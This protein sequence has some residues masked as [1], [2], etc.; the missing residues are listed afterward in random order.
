MFKVYLAVLG[1]MIFSS[2]MIRQNK[3]VTEDKNVYSCMV[4]L[5]NYYGEGAYVAVSLVDQFD[6]YVKTLRVLGDQKEW[7]PDMP[8]WWGFSKGSNEKLDGLTGATIA[9]GERSIFSIEIEEE[10]L[11]DGHKIRFETAVENQK[12]FEED[13]KV[14]LDSS[15]VTGKFEGTGY[16]RYVRI[17]PK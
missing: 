5:T 6:N 1:I 8:K 10:Y 2:F 9:G 13:L 7:Y 3:Q 4:Q 12:Y 14:V 11:N 17:M 16:I 15:S